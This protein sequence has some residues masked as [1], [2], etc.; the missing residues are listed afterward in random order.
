MQTVC[1]RC[2]KPLLARYDLERAVDLLDRGRLRGR[3]ATLWRYLELLPVRD[4]RHI[5][6][7]GEGWT[8]LLRARRL[9]EELG[10]R[11]LW[12]K[13]EGL[14]PTGTFKA[15]GLS[16]AVSR[17]LELGVRRVAMPSAGNAAAALAAYGAKAGLEVHVYMPRDAPEVNIVEAEAYGAEVTLVEG[18]ITDAARLLEGRA[19]EASWMVVSTLKEPYR[20]E[21]KKTMGYELAEQMDWRLPDVVIYPTGGG[22]GLIGMWKGFQELQALGWIDGRRPRMVS[23]QAAGCAP[24]VKAFREGRGEA[25]PW[26]RAQTIAS[27]LRVP[28]ALGD[29]LILGV[30]RESQGTAVAVGD[31][32]ILSAMRLMAR[33]EGVF[34]CPE[35]AATLAGLRRLVDEGWVDAD[36]RI[37][38]FNTGTGLKYTHLLGW[39]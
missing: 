20:L 23:V 12:I 16:V 33:L 39:A 30:L 35:G 32:E 1:P 17:A 3:D 29:F 28:K 38:L 2:G 18:L 25:E 26:P 36:E 31:D 34:P 9:G 13:D 8:P 11:A 6:S 21:G 14:N 5:V 27:G 4:R 10:L 15:R 22:T 7:L 37:V 24:I 19:R